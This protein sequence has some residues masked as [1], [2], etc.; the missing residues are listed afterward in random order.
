VLIVA[1][2]VVGGIFV[3]LWDLKASPPGWFFF[4]FK[5]GVKL[6]VVVAVI[7]RL[8]HLVH[9]RQQLTERPP[10]QALISFS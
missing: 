5:V 2:A 1:A 7:I 4:A 10:S 9:P 8:I 3:L 6:V